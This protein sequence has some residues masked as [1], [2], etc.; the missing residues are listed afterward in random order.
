MNIVMSPAEVTD[1]MDG[2]GIIFAGFAVHAN[3]RGFIYP[4]SNSRETGPTFR[5]AFPAFPGTVPGAR[6]EWARDR[7][8]GLAVQGESA[9]WSLAC[10]AV[11]TRTS[12]TWAR[13][14]ARSAAYTTAPPGGRQR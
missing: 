7:Q 11:A 9:G 3:E 10:Q 8:E 14:N 6:L 5:G 4:L 13:S 12:S 2:D 1:I